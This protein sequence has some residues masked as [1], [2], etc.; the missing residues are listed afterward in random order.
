M[1]NLITAKNIIDYYKKRI[2]YKDTYSIK[3]LYKNMK[4]YSEKE[5]QL[6]YAH[7]YKNLFLH[8]CL[9]NNTDIIIFLTKVYFDLSICDQI[10]LRQIVFYGKYLIPKTNQETIDWYS[11]YVIP[12]FKNI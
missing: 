9:K 11:N 8:S 4:T 1:N 7:I 6:N 10:A 2:E 12:I 3:E 5:Y